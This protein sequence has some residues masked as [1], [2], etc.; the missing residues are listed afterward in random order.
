MSGSGDT[1]AEELTPD[2]PPQGGRTPAKTGV[3]RDIVSRSEAAEKAGLSARQKN[4][5]L[6]VANV[7]RAEF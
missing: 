2:R 5:A 7:P 3:A 4:T 6:R 1:R